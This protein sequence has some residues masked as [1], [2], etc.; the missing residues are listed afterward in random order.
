[1]GW[2]LKNE[3]FLITTAKLVLIPSMI[4]INLAVHSA[5][6]IIETGIEIP[7]FIHAKPLKRLMN[8]YIP[9]LFVVEEC[10]RSP[11]VITPGS[12]LDRTSWLFRHSSASLGGQFSYN[13]TTLD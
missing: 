9:D 10:N 1:M 6:P 3:A 7:L 2:V 13:S 4:T 11:I 12:N 5:N 8:V